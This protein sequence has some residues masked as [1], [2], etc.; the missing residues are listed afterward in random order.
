MVRPPLGTVALRPGRGG[1]TGSVVH[2]VYTALF[3]EHYRRS[4]VKDRGRSPEGR[5]NAEG[6]IRDR[7]CHAFGP[8][9]T[10]TATGLSVAAG[11]HAGRGRN[12]HHACPANSVPATLPRVYVDF[13]DLGGCWNAVGAGLA[14]PQSQDWGGYGASLVLD[15]AAVGDARWAE[16]AEILRQ[17]WQ[18]L[19]RLDQFLENGAVDGGGGGP[20]TLAGSWDPFLD[21]SDLAVPRPTLFVSSW[22]LDSFSTV[23]RVDVSDPTRPVSRGFYDTPGYADALEVSG[24]T[25]SWS[26]GRRGWRSST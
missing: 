23:D 19:L 10:R 20:P 22:E 21:V 11:R 8:G 2:L 1:S 4:S 5:Q 17:R 13:T 16:P 7:A 6:R 12:L 9:A 24:V 14:N 3:P 26:R 25:C 18:G 15:L